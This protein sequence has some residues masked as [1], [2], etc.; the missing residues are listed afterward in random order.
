LQAAEAEVASAEAQF[1]RADT[2]LKRAERLFKQKAGSE[3]N[4][5]KWRGDQQVARAAIQ[6]AQSKVERAKL[7]LSY[8]QVVAPIGGR[9][10]RNLVDI[11]NLVGKGEATVLTQITQYDPMYVYVDLNEHDM[12]KVIRIYRERLK[13]R[14]IDPRTDP[15]RKAKIALEMG[16]SDD[17]G[18]PHQGVMDFAESGLDPDTGTVRLRGVFANSDVPVKLYPGLFAR[19]RMPFDQR[20]DMPLVSER[21]V[22]ADQSGAY[23]LVVDAEDTVEKRGVRLGRLEDGLRV[24]EEGV[25]AEDRVVVNGL[26]R[27]RPG[28]KVDPEETE[29][30][31]LSTSARKTASAASGSGE[32]GLAEQSSESAQQ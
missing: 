6:R 12:L 8:T 22:G 5:V 3:A 23:V 16:L 25:Q 18:Y 7:E 28:G 26:Q 15:A 2:E 27:A 19:V 17:E 1:K 4:V 32:S 21:A 20:A 13:E 10:G 30:A 24:I 9:V 29:M 11:G 31:S 14:G